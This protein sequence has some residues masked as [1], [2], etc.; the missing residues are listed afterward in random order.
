VSPVTSHSN[1]TPITP[2]YTYA[3]PSHLLTHSH[4]TPV[5]PITHILVK[6]IAEQGIEEIESQ[7]VM[8]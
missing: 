7:A 8:S 5:T 1:D 6:K 3:Q 2:H 4:K